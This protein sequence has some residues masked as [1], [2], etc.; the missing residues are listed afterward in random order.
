[1]IIVNG[2]IETKVKSA[3]GINPATGFPN[4]SQGSWSTPIPCQYIPNAH[5][6][7]GIANGE[8]YV[9]AKYA[10]LI[11]LMQFSSE[12]IRLKD[13]QGNVIGEFSVIS[14]EPLQAVDELKILV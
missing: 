12:Q 11:D 6:N 9:Q 4:V 13:M 3:A 1:M 7:L 14:V 2:T 5:N 10:I 8:H